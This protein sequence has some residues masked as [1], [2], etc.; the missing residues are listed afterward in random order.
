MLSRSS[1]SMRLRSAVVIP[2]LASLL[3]GYFAFYTFFGERSLLRLM[4]IE[5]KIQTTQTKLDGVKSEH[6]ALAARVQHMRPGSLDTDLV[7]EQARRVLNYSAPDEI[8]IYEKRNWHG[9]DNSH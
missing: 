1:I 4:R 8:V 9:S 6:D 5:A 3:I 7:D 2:L